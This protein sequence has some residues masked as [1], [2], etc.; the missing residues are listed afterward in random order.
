MCWY[1]F[2]QYSI[3]V[4]LNFYNMPHWP[5]TF[6]L[7]QKLTESPGSVKL[8]IFFNHAVDEIKVCHFVTIQVLDQRWSPV[9]K[10][11][12]DTVMFPGQGYHTCYGGEWSS[13][14]GNWWCVEKNLSLLLH[15]LLISYK[16]IWNWYWDWQERC[17]HLTASVWHSSWAS[18]FN[19]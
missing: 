4:S 5:D 2:L 3:K 10:M 18:K 1:C 9:L 12:D 8:G 7:Y 17:Q 15:P 14:G 19:P 13:A 16:G 11:T 6:S